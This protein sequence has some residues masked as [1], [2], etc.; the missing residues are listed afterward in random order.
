MENKQK[1]FKQCDMCK[2]DEATSLCPQCF[3]YYCD[4]C[5]KQVHEKKEN[6]EHK[7]EA[8]DYNVP[9]DTRCPEHDMV[10]TNLF[11]I[12]EKGKIYEYLIIYRTLLLILPLFKSS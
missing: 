6:K 4:G 9:I 5:F 1:N 11:C 2:V 8:I 10:P 3:S 7:K 12:D